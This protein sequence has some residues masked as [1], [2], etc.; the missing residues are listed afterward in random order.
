MIFYSSWEKV[1]TVKQQRD[2]G[3]VV[4]CWFGKFSE[5]IHHLS[6]EEDLQS[7]MQAKEQARLQGA[8]E[9]RKV[10]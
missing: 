7:H 2:A 8:E 3:S 1:K 9:K 10:L 4:L 5:S 6:A